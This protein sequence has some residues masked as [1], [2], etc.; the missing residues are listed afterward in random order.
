MKILATLK[1]EFLFLCIVLN[2]CSYIYYPTHPV[3]PKE[4]SGFGVEA[5][6]GINRVQVSGWN[7]FNKN[8]YMVSNLAGAINNENDG[9]SVSR[10]VYHSVSGIIGIGIVTKLSK[11]CDFHYQVGAGYS[12]GYFRTSAFGETIVNVKSQ[13][14]RF[15]FRPALGF[16]EGESS[17]RIFIVPKITYESFLSL[18]NHPT[19]GYNPMYKQTS[20]LRPRNFWI[21]ELYFQYKRDLGNQW[22]LDYNFGFSTGLLEYKA[23]KPRYILPSYVVSKPFLFN[24]GICKQF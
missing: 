5:S 22:N 10:R 19:Y 4:N 13:G 9:D 24:I 20:N 3:I 12:R 1:L 7:S 11:I 17:N 23:Y 16:H 18:E 8:I 14:Y 21:Y 2:S 15:Y 6:I